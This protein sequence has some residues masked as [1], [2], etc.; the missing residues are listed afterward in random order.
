MLK[1]LI[2]SERPG[3]SPSVSGPEG[4]GEARRQW[5]S[6][7]S[8]TFFG[9]DAAKRFELEA[10]TNETDPALFSHA[11][12]GFAAR[13]E[14]SGKL[15]AALA[16]YQSILEP[17]TE[18]K[19]N[20]PWTQEAQ[21]RARERL[22][23]IAGGGSTGPRFE[24]L[25]T[26]F[27]ADATDY[28][29]I[30]PM[31]AGS[32][33]YQ[34]T[35]LALLGRLAGKYSPAAAKW[36]AT[37]AGFSV[38]VPV[39]SLGARALRQASGEPV[40][41]GSEEVSRDLASAAITLG[42]LKSTG[43]VGQGLATRVLGPK[44]QVG[45]GYWLYSQGL[46]VTGMM[47]AHSLESSWGLRPKS[48]GSDAFLDAVS[49][50]LS[51]SVGA[52]LARRAL[53][54]DLTPLQ[55]ELET[56]L[57]AKNN[58]AL[59]LA[60]L[61]GKRLAASDGLQIPH[62]FFVQNS[63]ESL[64]NRQ[65]TE[66]EYQGWLKKHVR[67][68]ADFLL[69]Q[70]PDDMLYLI[71]EQLDGKNL[72]E[73]G[74]AYLQVNEYKYFQENPRIL[75]K[76]LQDLRERFLKDAEPSVFFA[77]AQLY[78]EGLHRVGPLSSELSFA[79]QV[80]R[81]IVERETG[82]F[83]AKRNSLSALL[84]LIRLQAISPEEAPR[85]SEVLSRIL[86]DRLDNHG[87][88]TYALQVYEKLA[89]AFSPDPRELAAIRGIA[90]KMLQ[91]S[92]ALQLVAMQF[93]HGLAER[94]PMPAGELRR[95]AEFL[96][97]KW[98]DEHSVLAQEAIQRSLKIAALFPPGDPVVFQEAEAVRKAFQEPILEELATNYYLT[99]S[100]AFR[101]GESSALQKEFY[102]IIELLKQASQSGVGLTAESYTKL[103]DSLFRNH[104]NF[105]G[106]GLWEKWIQGE[107]WVDWG[108]SP[109]DGERIVTR[110]LRDSRGRLMSTREHWKTLLNYFLDL[111]P[112]RLGVLRGLLEGGGKPRDLFSALDAVLMIPSDL[113]PG[114][115]SGILAQMQGWP[116]EATAKSPGRA[117]RLKAFVYSEL[118]SQMGPLLRSDP[119]SPRAW[120]SNGPMIE[121]LFKSGTLELFIRAAGFMS[122]DGR[123]IL[124]DLLDRISREPVVEGKVSFEGR[125]DELLKWGFPQA[126]VEAWRRDYQDGAL[127]VSGRVE[128][129][130]RH[131]S[132]PEETCQRLTAFSNDETNG[133]GQPLLRI[134]HGQFKVANVVQEGRVVARRL[135]E[136][137]FQE[138]GQPA[139][140]VHRL[141]SEGGFS[142]DKAFRESL[143]KYAVS[144][145]IPS[146]RIYFAERDLEKV[147]MPLN[148]HP[149]IYRDDWQ[150]AVDP[151]TMA[152]ELMAVALEKTVSPAVWAP[153]LGLSQ[154]LRPQIFWELSEYLLPGALIGLGG[155]A[156]RRWL[157]SRRKKTAPPP[158][159]SPQMLSPA[160][161]DMHLGRNSETEQILR[162]EE[163]GEDYW[164]RLENSRIYLSH[165]EDGGWW[166]KSDSPHVWLNGR[167]LGKSA[168]SIR[169][170][171]L[172]QIGRKVMK[173]LE[174]YAGEF[175]PESWRRGEEAHPS[176]L[177]I[178]DPY[179][180]L[181]KRAL[182]RGD[183]PSWPRERREA[184]WRELLGESW[185]RLV[186]P[187]LQPASAAHVRAIRREIGEELKKGYATLADILDIAQIALRV[188]GANLPDYTKAY[189][190]RKIALAAA[191]M[192]PD[193]HPSFVHKLDF[194]KKLLDSL[195]LNLL[196]DDIPVHLRSSDPLNVA[197]IFQADGGIWQ[198]GRS[199]DFMGIESSLG[200]LRRFGAL[201]VDEMH[202]ISTVKF[203]PHPSVSSAQLPL[204]YVVHFGGSLRYHWMGA[205][206]TGGTL[207]PQVHLFRL[208]GDL[209]SPLIF[210]QFRLRA[211]AGVALPF[212]AE[213]L[214]KTRAFARPK[215]VGLSELEYSL[216]ALFPILLLEDPGWA[217]LRR[218]FILGVDLRQV[219]ESWHELSEIPELGFH[220]YDFNPDI[221]WRISLKT[222]SRAQAQQLMTRPGGLL[223]WL[224][225]A[226]YSRV[227]E[228]E[229]SVGKKH[230]F[231][232]GKNLEGHGVRV[233]VHFIY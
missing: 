117:T 220:S 229:V 84:G 107:R 160:Y 155:L 163:V 157:A 116:K 174:P 80:L 146:T 79:P 133:E 201:R 118:R 109:Q 94:Y 114:I 36:M 10:I 16:I 15:E 41:W 56:R 138:P 226:G 73:L 4:W 99:L 152:R 145:G 142:G 230:V 72:Q 101:G 113:R 126:F 178:S 135:L 49:A 65:V 54:V 212:L 200:E 8:K 221:P 6:A 87:L 153:A 69:D 52:H 211:P 24:F 159:G 78:A 169:D 197:K 30:L 182:D 149:E 158:L 216:D 37:A 170:G 92:P 81:G 90:L 31:F 98:N 64:G 100:K 131:G 18:S 105:Q 44:P 48:A 70:Y 32:L 2:S 85:L 103:V 104:E 147:P 28:R 233:K 205:T 207:A 139:L 199:P 161:H 223:E 121:A 43:W 91:G 50:T 134:L 35:R 209:P 173:F 5:I 29:S 19:G 189:F 179:S 132:V 27:V 175:W 26:R 166:V 227:E 75:D 9:S 181:L 67:E 11:I 198:L 217:N 108:L 51:L 206:P 86:L 184:A 167:A 185:F 183:A 168:T 124:G 82:D 34:G 93:L 20:I 119:Q 63:G 83:P 3:L 122:P 144:L 165:E 38:E 225:K 25:M 210:R 143:E 66:R 59:A 61:I 137:T 12:L 57:Q 218:H 196:P 115:L 111:D 33:A 186:E 112:M 129:M 46:Q 224:E 193:R 141:F 164:D 127:Q 172:L 58:G 53:R 208:Q 62:V 123:K 204:R 68:M 102:A 162:K 21:D 156:L 89:K 23:A 125:Y 42:M 1:V 22:G 191:E 228:G 74:N 60:P 188:R 154:I 106:A 130:A 55:R 213:I 203:S 222:R 187:L 88:K 215:D 176:D 232:S 148:A 76:T 96:R 190:D 195:L 14:Q 194:A 71:K 150:I 95:F 177:M 110:L 77:A 140:L 97:E 231:W 47:A 219:A 40:G 202:F 45:A 128:V 214:E 136:V 192:S 13:V 120:E 39:F 17:Q 171:D 7:I 151:K 180:G